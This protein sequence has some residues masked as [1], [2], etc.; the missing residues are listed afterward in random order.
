MKNLSFAS[1]L[2]CACFLAFFTTSGFSQTY[3]IKSECGKYL[4]VQNLSTNSGTPIVLN[5]YSAAL[6]QQWKIVPRSR[7]NGEYIFYIE[8]VKSGKY[9]D[10]VWGKDADGTKVQLWDFTGG[11]AQ[12]WTFVTLEG[13]SFKGKSRIV[14][15]LGGKNLDKGGGPCDNN[16]PLMI[17]T[18]NDS[19]AQMW[20]LE[21]ILPPAA[22][23]V[24]QAAPAKSSTR[25]VMTRSLRN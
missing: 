22:P 24:M 17:W 13:T 6:S 2:L 4:T 18:R 8:S 5:D 15:Q 23:P 1:T 14:S 20:Y 25:P 3:Y 19:A 10:V 7:A 16:T 9:L 12:E 21:E 11:P